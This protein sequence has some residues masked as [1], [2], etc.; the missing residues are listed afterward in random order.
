M[1]DDDVTTNYT[2]IVTSGTENRVVRQIDSLTF[3][4]DLVS[5]TNRH[6]VHRIAGVGSRFLAA[7]YDGFIQCVAAAALLFASTQLNFV[8][9]LPSWLLVFATVHVGYYLAFE[10]LT[11]GQSPGKNVVGLRVVSICGASP[12]FRQY[13]VRNVARLLDFL[14]AAYFAGGMRALMT[15]PSCRWGDELAGT[16][17]VCTEPFPVM[18]TRIQCGPAAYNVS[19]DAYLLESFVLRQSS[20]PVEVVAQL[21]PL[22]AD[23][24]SKRYGFFGDA[25]LANLYQRGDYA[26]YLFALYSREQA[27][28]PRTEID[29]VVYE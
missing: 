23:Y 24:F 12:K 13:L 18:L 9:S 5:G 14:P 3:V 17:V 26:N 2:E 19:A 20:L 4:I 7:L 8:L 6:S 1:S 16:V 10:L 15:V 29:Y 21:A 11:K 28:A 22:L 27:N 25:K